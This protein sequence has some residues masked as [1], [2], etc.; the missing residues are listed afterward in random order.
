MP[1]P[2]ADHRGNTPLV[3]SALNSRRGIPDR[4]SILSTHEIGRG[5]YLP[6]FSA[7]NNA[8]KSPPIDRST[9]ARLRAFESGSRRKSDTWGL[10]GSLNWCGALVRGPCDKGS[11]Y[12]SLSPRGEGYTQT[13]WVQ[14]VLPACS[15]ASPSLS[16]SMSSALRPRWFIGPIAGEVVLDS[17]VN[18][19]CS[20]PISTSWR[21]VRTC[22]TLVGMGETYQVQVAALK[23][24][25][26]PK[27]RMSTCQSRKD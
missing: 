5:I 18:L 7:K 13:K 27:W 25:D 10:Q 22:N 19:R 4:Q 12:T 1:P 2:L 15:A 16:A 26:E 24:R 14:W 21:S 23:E 9:D 11:P 17:S 20:C 6:W 8:H 3:N